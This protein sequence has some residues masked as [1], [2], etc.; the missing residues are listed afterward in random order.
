MLATRK[1]NCRLNSFFYI[2]HYETAKK[3]DNGENGAKNTARGFGGRDKFQTSFLYFFYDE[4]R[5]ESDI[6]HF[7]LKKRFHG[8][9]FL[10]SQHINR[11]D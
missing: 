7:N 1:N 2:A 11:S 8:V 6:K 4:I 9:F 5:S 10:L 3:F